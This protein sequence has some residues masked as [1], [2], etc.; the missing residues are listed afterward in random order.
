VKNK[1]FKIYFLIGST[2][3]LCVLFFVFNQKKEPGNLNLKNFVINRVKTDKKVVA[4]T[5]DADMTPNMLQ[6][7]QKHQIETW[8]DDKLIEELKRQKIPATLFLTGMWIE[9]YP[10]LTEELSKN[11]LFEIG[12]HS[13]SHPG[14]TSNCYSLKNI[15]NKE[16]DQRI[17]KTDR[18]LKN[19]AVKHSK[20]FRFPGLCYEK[21]DLSAVFENDYIA[22]GGDVLGDDG[23]E[24]NL[25][26]IENHVV[27]E[28][29]PGS[30][31]VLHMMGGPNAPKTNEAIKE[32]IKK[33]KNKGYGFVTISEL[34]EMGEP[35]K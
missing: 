25:E 26:F 3:L 13:Y 29:R 5:F 10:S 11:P 1:Y 12:N 9:L 7:I 6:K 30:I 34:L 33:L 18:L 19:Y 35:E 17:T 2:I 24:N 15:N 4:L 16:N 27:S 32:I 22:I 28:V 8:Y 20:I 14:F 23:F 21:E 31:V